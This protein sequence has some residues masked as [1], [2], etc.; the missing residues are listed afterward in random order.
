MDR[1]FTFAVTAFEEMSPRR[2]GGRMIQDCIR[3]ALSH[4]TIDEIVIVNDGSDDGEKTFSTVRSFAEG[5]SAS[6]ADKIR[7][8]HYPENLGAFGNKLRAVHHASNEWVINCDSDNVMGE[9][10]DDAGYAYF[11]IVDA[12]PLE[13][14]TWFCPSFARTQ[15]DYRHMMGVYDLWALNA[16][17]DAPRIECML[18]TGN[19]IVHRESFLGVFD[20][21]RETRFDLMVRDRLGWTE[22]QRQA[23]KHREVWNACD[24]LFYNIEWLKAGGRLHVATG[25]EYGHRVKVQGNYD[26]APTEK[27]QLARLLFEELRQLIREAQQ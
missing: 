17:V 26:R 4:P 16:I 23:I 9:E 2:N 10:Y 14:Q 6:G 25:L 5:L 7:T 13:T 12:L 20:K 27:T 3:L 24:S 22:E 11:Q 21:Y 8:F 19:Q 18:N 15:F 1:K